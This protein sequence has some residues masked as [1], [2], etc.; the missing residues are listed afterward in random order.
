[1]DFDEYFKPDISQRVEMSNGKYRLFA[2]KEKGEGRTKMAHEQ[3]AMPPVPMDMVFN[4]INEF[5]NQLVDKPI[6]L[7]KLGSIALDGKDEDIIGHG[8]WVKDTFNWKPQSSKP[9]YLSSDK[10]YTIIQE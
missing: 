9:P 2:L 1:M 6:S 10:K 8:I 4:Y 7:S 3:V 5:L